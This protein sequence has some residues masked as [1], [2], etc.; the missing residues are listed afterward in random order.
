MIG[1][2]CR[3]SIRCTVG[4]HMTNIC[5]APAASEEGATSYSLLAQA[6]VAPTDR[7]SLGATYLERR[8]EPAAMGGDD[9]AGVGSEGERRPEVLGA[10]QRGGPFPFARRATAGD[11]VERELGATLALKLSDAAVL[12]GWA[13][14]DFDEVESKLQSRQLEE[15]RPQQ[16]GVLLGSFPDGSGSGWAL[17]MGRSGPAGAGVAPNLGELSLQFDMG[18]G[19]ILTPGMVV[20]KQGLT[21]HTAFLGVN[22][23]WTF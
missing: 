15:V 23:K 2:V 20:M 9:A 16:W 18:D 3:S 21:G 7:L 19:L 1:L 22:S 12:H 4:K 11:E 6:V 10:L 5:T 14:A 17:G 13:A 8:S